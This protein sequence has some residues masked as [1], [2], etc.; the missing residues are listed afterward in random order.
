MAGTSWHGLLEHDE[1]RTAVLT[2][3]ARR[4]GRTHR[5]GPERFAD[6][7]ERRLDVLGDLVAEHLDTDALL[8]LLE[9]GVPAGLPTLACGPL[10]G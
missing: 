3:A 1:A 6:V 7:R 9:D 10:A 5:P 4:A 2:W 8:R